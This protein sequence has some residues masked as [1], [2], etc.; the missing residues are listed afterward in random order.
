MGNSKKIS[1]IT[2]MF[3]ALGLIPAMAADSVIPET[4]ITLAETQNVR[5]AAHASNFYT[6]SIPI[7]GVAFSANIFTPQ[8][9]MYKFGLPVSYVKEGSPAEEA[10]IRKGDVLLKVDGQK[11][12]YGNQFA[13]LIRTYRP[14]D[15]V[16]VE[17]VRGNELHTQDLKLGMRYGRSLDHFVTTSTEPEPNEKDDV[18]I[19]VNGREI[20]LSKNSEWKNRIA[21]TPDAIIIRTNSD[22]PG[23]LQKVLER[24]RAHLPTPTEVSNHIKHSIRSIQNGL[25][26]SV[27]IRRQV[28]TWNDDTVIF[29]VEGGKREVTVRTKGNKEVFCGPCTTREEID[30]IPEDIREII[31][32]FTPLE[33]LEGAEASEGDSGEKNKSTDKK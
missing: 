25:G 13:A 1:M 24:F 33:P 12:F 8:R 22:I 2:P 3:L 9:K 26:S 7:L 27:H 4:K 28:F 30:A 11:I 20:S 31:R 16:K 21:V 18:R 19:V 23:E 32:K 29:N 15:T 14:G 6:E 10:G 17:F 5:R